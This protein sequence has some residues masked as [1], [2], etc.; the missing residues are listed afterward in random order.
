MITRLLNFKKSG[1]ALSIWQL[2]TSRFGL[3]SHPS[4]RNQAG[5]S[6]LWPPGGAEVLAVI[7]TP[8]TQAGRLEVEKVTWLL[9]TSITVYFFVFDVL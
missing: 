5:H 8:P 9:G 2:D 1:C 7:Q 4:P 3:A 6:R